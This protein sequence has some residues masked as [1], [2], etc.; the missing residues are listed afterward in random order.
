MDIL[1]RKT[2]SML[3]IG[4]VIS[5]AAFVATLINAAAMP[6]ILATG[7]LIVFT[8]AIAVI[9]IWREAHKEGQLD[10]VELAG[11]SFGAR[12]GVA[13]VIIIALLATF[14]PPLQSGIN[15]MAAAFEASPASPIPASVRLFIAGL[16]CAMIVQLATKSLITLAWRRSK[17]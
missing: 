3:D 2:G 8:L 9:G 1:K 14:V 6:G 12:W 16:V 15:V 11:A 7:L 4:L 13:A 17:R 10:E 5:L